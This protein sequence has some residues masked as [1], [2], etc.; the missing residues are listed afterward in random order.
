MPRYLISLGYIPD[1]PTNRFLAEWAE[2]AGTIYLSNSLPGSE[3]QQSAAAGGLFVAY[4][5]WVRKQLA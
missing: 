2:V 3:I 4:D 1:T 5:A